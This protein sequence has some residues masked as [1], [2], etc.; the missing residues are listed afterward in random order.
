MDGLQSYKARNVREAI[1]SGAAMDEI[2]LLVASLSLDVLV[3]RKG[4]MAERHL[5]E[6]SF[7]IKQAECK[8]N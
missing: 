8:E 4:K 6:R 3:Y 5:D 2:F 7:C 1:V